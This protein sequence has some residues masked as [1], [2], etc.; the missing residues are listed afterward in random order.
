MLDISLYAI[1]PIARSRLKKSGSLVE[2]SQVS[3]AVL[4]AVFAYIQRI[5]KSCMEMRPSCT[6]RARRSIIP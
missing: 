4:V 3:T 6:E 5:H 1:S 2:I